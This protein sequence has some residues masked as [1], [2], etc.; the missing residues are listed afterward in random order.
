MDPRIREHAQLVAEAVGLSAGDNFVIKSEP[1]ADDLVTAL[2]EIAGERGA[3]PL[4]VRTNRSGG[5][6]R[7]YLRAAS[8]ADVEFETPGHQ[9]AL[10]EAADCHAIIRAH[11]NVT[12]LGDVDSETNAAYESGHS[13]ILDERLGDRWTLTQHPAPANAQL[14]EMSSEGYENFV[15]DAILKDWD[16]Q[17]DFQ[18]NL[19]EILDPA[20]EVRIVSGEST[21]VTMSIAGNHAINDTDTHNLPGGE[22]FTAPQPDTVEGEVHFDKPVYQRGSEVTDVRLT[23]EDGEVVEHSAEKNED[24]LTSILDTDEGARRLGELGIG[25]NR[26]ITQLT[27]NILFDEKMARTIHLALGRAYNACLPDG[28]TGNDSA[29]HVDLITDMR[30]SSQLSVDGEVL[31]RNGYFEWE[32]EFEG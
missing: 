16:E 3:H 28:K 21:D 18:E 8:E 5:A 31:Q 29:V 13:P 11:E 19:V 15:Y 4:A 14:A 30:G 9:Q 17:R 27:D 6:I 2:Y 25:M 12:E 7:A 32:D 10:I 20:E 1:R 23:F 24:L 26:G 22:V